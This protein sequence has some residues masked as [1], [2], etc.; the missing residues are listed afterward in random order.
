MSVITILCHGTANSTNTATS[1]GSE[2]V[3]SKI[4]TLLAGMDGLNWILN[5]GAG[6]AELKDQHNMF[7]N[8]F[9]KTRGLPGIAAG[10]GVGANVRRSLSFVKTRLE[11][12]KDLT[13]N[14]AGHSRGSI[15]CYKIAYQ[16]SQTYGTKIP[17]NI[18]AIDP[19]PGNNG[20][21]NAGMYRHIDLGANLTNSFLMLAES[22]HRQ[23][24][25]P[26]IDELYTMGNTRHKFDTMPGTHGGINELTGSES[27]AAALVLSRALRFL[28]KHGSPL[29]NEDR[30][31]LDDA[32]MLGMYSKL[33]MRINEYKA[34]ASVKPWKSPLNFVMTSGNVEKHRIVNVAGAKDVWG[35]RQPWEVAGS[36]DRGRDDHHGLG[37]ST[38]LQRMGVDN[39]HAQRSA[40]FFANKEHERLFGKKYP[41]LM[42]AI[43]NLELSPTD[44]NVE[45]LKRAVNTSANLIRAMDRATKDYFYTFCWQR[46][47]PA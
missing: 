38:A 34:H 7:G 45:V 14:L 25:R 1:N 32:A 39:P 5:E 31:I 6:T 41:T 9:G 30:F 42:S 37:L 21:M 28:K 4:S 35:T 10:E 8:Q 26:Y 18:F 17:V 11:N 47:V 15:T 2:L 29:N 13:V 16:L 27:E 23:N 33:M 44:Q 3:I 19:V 22:E 40:R 36:V 12:D 43:R 46:N 24:F 20:S